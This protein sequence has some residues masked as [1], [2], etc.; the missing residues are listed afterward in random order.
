MQRIA[1]NS[2]TGAKLLEEFARHDRSIRLD[3]VR[4][5]A[6]EVA[7]RDAIASTKQHELLG[8]SGA[9]FELSLLLTQAEA[10]TYAAHLAKV[11][12]EHDGQPGR[13]RALAGL[14]QDMERLYLE[15]VALLL[16]RGK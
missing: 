4:L 13:A 1:V 14:S 5:P 12:S 3:D 6:G 8:Q 2:A 7:A 10:L 15:I 11:A 9:S 16:E